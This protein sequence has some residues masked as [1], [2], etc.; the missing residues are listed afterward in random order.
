MRA[1]LDA[2]PFAHG[3][4]YGGG[5]D[6]CGGGGAVPG[7]GEPVAALELLLDGVGEHEGIQPVPLA[8]ELGGDLGAN[9]WAREDPLQRCLRG[10]VA[11][12]D[13]RADPH[14]GE[15]LDRGQ[16][17]IL[18]E[19]QLVTVQGVDR[20]L[21]HRAV[22]THVAQELADTSAVL[23]L[24]VRVIILLVGP[25][26]RELDLVGIWCL[27][28]VPGLVRRYS[29]V[30]SR[31][32]WGARRRSIWRG[33]MARN[34]AS[35]AGRSRSRRRAQ[36][37]HSGSRASTAATTDSPRLPRSPAASRSPP[38]RRSRAGPRPSQHA[39][40]MLPVIPGHLATLIQL[41]HAA[42]RKTRRAVKCLKCAQAIDLGDTVESAGAPLTHVDCRYPH[43]VDG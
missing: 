20:G 25:P 14:L 17:E 34:C 28:K 41:L 40:G 37:S 18:Q 26:P 11:A 3:A 21:S 24:D 5:V 23:L 30:V 42:Q 1:R 10:I 2:E 9:V 39:D 13:A 15:Q 7:T 12:P 33:L 29:R 6:G 4:A 35:T 22:V 27:S 43:G 31:R 8:S 19:P 32:R 36:G 16:E 38:R